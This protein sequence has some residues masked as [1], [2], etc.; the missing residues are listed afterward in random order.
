MLGKGEL[1]PPA[2][3]QGGDFR[4]VGE[5]VGGDAQALAQG[6][7]EPLLPLL[8]AGQVDVLDRL[9]LFGG[10]ELHHGG[11]Q[12]PDLGGG[13]GGAPPLQQAGA[14]AKPVSYTHLVAPALAVN[15]FGAGGALVPAAV[16]AVVDVVGR[17]VAAVV[18][19]G[20][21]ENH[22]GVF[23]L[24]L[25]D[26]IVVGLD[27]KGLDVHLQLAP[28]AVFLVDGVA[29]ALVVDEGGVFVGKDA[30]DPQLLEPLLLFIL[31]EGIVPHDVDVVF[32][33]AGACLLYTSF[34]WFGK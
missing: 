24:V 6:R 18:W 11:E 20:V 17:P 25:L 2:A 4:A 26:R 22:Q 9:P 27:V 28:A 3:G 34:S 10:V 33:G 31:A 21:G 19:V 13:L 1:A 5:G 7:A 15:G 30:L 16:V 32:Q 29:K 14:V 12:P 23:R 8:K